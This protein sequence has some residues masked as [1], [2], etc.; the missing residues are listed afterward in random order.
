MVHENTMTT[1]EQA[2]SFEPAAEIEVTELEAF[3]VLSDALRSRLLDLLRAEP[4]TVKQLSTQL[5]L[6]P[7]K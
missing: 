6:S 2:D 3:R 1:Q 7:K 5:N 4:L